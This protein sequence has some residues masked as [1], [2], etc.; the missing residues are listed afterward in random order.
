ME[1]EKLEIQVKNLEIKLGKEKEK[2]KLLKRE[3][4]TEYAENKNNK[5]RAH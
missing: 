3:L 1:N 2:V 4:H 5:R